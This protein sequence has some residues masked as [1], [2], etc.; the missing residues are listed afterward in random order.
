MVFDLV[1]GRATRVKPRRKEPER[2]APDK[3]GQDAPAPV[4]PAL[5]D[6]TLVASTPKKP[7]LPLHASTNDLLTNGKHIEKNKSNYAMWLKST[8]LGLGWGIREVIAGY[9]I[10]TPTFQRW[11]GDGFGLFFMALFLAAA[12]V[13]T[14]GFFTDRVRLVLDHQGNAMLG[15]D[16][17][18]ESANPLPDNLAIEAT[19]HQLNITRTLSFPSML[20]SAQGFE[21]VE[22]QA[23]ESGYPLRGTLRARRLDSSGPP[24][25]SLPAPGTLWADPD[26]PERLSLPPGGMVTLGEASFELSGLIEEESVRGSQ[27][28]QF[29]PRVIVPLENLPATGLV[30]PASRVT[31]RLLVAGAAAPVA[32]FDQWLTSHLPAG[33]RRL[34]SRQG[35][36]EWRAALERMERLLGLSGL[37]SVLV[38]GAAVALA[39][40]RFVRRQADGIAILRTLGATRSWLIRRHLPGLLG[41][42]LSAGL[43]GGMAGWLLQGGL[44][45][46]G[47]G[48]FAPELPDATLDPML[49]GLLTSLLT[50]LGFALPPLWELP[51]IAPLRVLRQDL[52][53]PS[54]TSL[55]TGGLA[56]AAFTAL[57]IWQT[58]DLALALT[59]LPMVAVA[60]MVLTGVGWLLLRSLGWL[61]P[62]ARGLARHALA[63]N[64]RAP[65]ATLLQVAAFGLGLTALLFLT[66][67]HHDLLTLWRAS[68]PPDTPNRFLI[69]IQPDQV[70]SLRARLIQAGVPQPRLYPMSRARLTAIEGHPVEPE[71]Y[72]EER[73]RQLAAREFNLGEATQPQAGNRVIQGRWWAPGAPLEFSV[74]QGIAG[75]LGIALGSRLTFTIAGQ[76]IEAPVTSLRAVK[77]DSFE[78]NFFV[79][80]PPGHLEKQPRTYITSFYHDPGRSG[81]LRTLLRDYPSLTVIDVEAILKQV[82]VLLERGAQAIEFLTLFTLAG[83]LLVFY[84]GLQSRLEER[85]NDAAVLKTL[86]AT[87]RQMAAMLALEWAVQGFIAGLVGVLFAHV[88]GQVIAQQFLDAVFPFDLWLSVAGLVGGTL[89][90]GLAGFLLSRS[91][92]RTP[93]IQALQRV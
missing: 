85:A 2:P 40:R 80:A 9:K 59:V 68:L 6:F 55:A 4:A 69:N 34:D 46:F 49:A 8:A 88:I 51:R 15:A 28:F 93:P 27:L 57:A 11:R 86:G 19:R 48:W 74:E 54:P 79:V 65:G 84:G 41:L 56:L 61:T 71:H 18:V 47:R 91:L 24:S 63:V 39:S 3:P 83:G 29:A 53:P 75:R 76:A 37:V 70:E 90:M 32:D 42:S 14:V 67:V 21:M 17:V 22:I 5:R 58:R 62:L 36:P 77:W 35:R 45:Y 78:V 60:L 92:W 89:G 72:D 50:T 31:H 7:D 52:P 10:L 44:A 73:T 30:T 12:T 23:V 16:L 81:G 87:T 20:A 26:L 66:F 1:G 38:A 33:A 13:S 25:G 64:A 82:R 43:L